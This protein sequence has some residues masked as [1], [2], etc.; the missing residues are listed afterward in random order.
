MGFA[1]VNYKQTLRAYRISDKYTREEIW[2]ITY[3]R[4]DRL[5]EVLD[6]IAR[7]PDRVGR[8]A[9]TYRDELRKQ[10]EEEAKKR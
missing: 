5:I 4:R 3:R 9:A 2:E 10:I 8:Y 1:V 7:T 6:R